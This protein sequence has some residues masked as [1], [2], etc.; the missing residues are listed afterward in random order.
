MVAPLGR[1]LT[2]AEA[3][4]TF[5]GWVRLAQS[6]AGKFRGGRHVDPTTDLARS[7]LLPGTFNRKLKANPRLVTLIGADG[8]RFNPSD[9]E[10]CRVG[11]GHRPSPPLCGLPWLVRSRT[12]GRATEVA[13]WEGRIRRFG[14]DAPLMTGGA[15]AAE[16]FEAYHSY[17]KLVVD[18]A[19]GGALSRHLCRRLQI[20]DC[21]GGTKEREGERRGSDAPPP[22]LRLETVFSPAGDRDGPP[23]SIGW[24]PR[25]NMCRETW[26]DD[27]LLLQRYRSSVSLLAAFLF[28]LD[29]G[30]ILLHSTFCF[31]TL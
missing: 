23:G 4:D 2:R 29:C 26:W 18:D 28:H 8:L 6:L 24:G 31:G 10:L 27:V 9:F 3:A 1:S 13:L 21:P 14:L 12:H 19:E 22:R 11:E 15:D 30:Q 25:S 20:L 17:D 16:R 7:L 5:R